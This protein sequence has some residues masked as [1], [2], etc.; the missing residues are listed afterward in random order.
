MNS[1]AVFR[2]ASQLIKASEGF[3]DVAYRDIAGVWTI[4]WG[5]TGAGVGPGVTMSLEDA[6][7]KLASSLAFLWRRILKDLNRHLNDN[8]AAALLS[9]TYNVGLGAI[10]RSTLW[11]YIR[12]GDWQPAADEFLRWDKATVNGI[13]VVLS[14]LKARR[15]AERALFLAPC[16][17]PKA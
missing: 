7:V 11:G 1:E 13:L 3:R 2:I 14:G 12:T 17:Q 6:N 9:L 10:E 8:Q 4:G 5:F 16:D 15:T